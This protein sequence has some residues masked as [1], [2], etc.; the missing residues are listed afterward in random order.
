MKITIL[1]CGPAASQLPCG[2][3]RYPPA[4]LVEVGGVKVLFDCSEGVR[5]RLEQAGYNYADIHH[6]ALTHAHPDHNALA[7]YIQAIFCHGLWGGLKNQE[8]NIYCPKSIIDTFWALWNIYHPDWPKGLPYPR[9][10]FHDMSSGGCNSLKI[11]DN[12]ILSSRVVFHAGGKIECVAF[13][14]QTPEGIFAY[15]GDSGQCQGLQEVCQE[16]DLFICEAAAR[17]KH[18]ESSCSGHMDPYSVGEICQKGKVK[19]VIITHYTGLDSDEA[20]IKECRR[21]GYE[22]EIVVGKDFQRFEI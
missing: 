10:T 14:L 20:I 21:S 1:G 5:F 3:S 12:I 22:G 9:L 7:H 6:V 16:A 19:K 4:Y 18:S 8:L 11:F 17:I 15:S 13:R 2:P